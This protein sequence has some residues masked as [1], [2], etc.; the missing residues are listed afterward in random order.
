MIWLEVEFPA[1]KT[2][3]YLKLILKIGCMNCIPPLNTGKDFDLWFTYHM[4]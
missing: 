2:Q 3:C 1:M 4:S